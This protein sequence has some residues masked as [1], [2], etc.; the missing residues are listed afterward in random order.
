MEEMQAEHQVPWPLPGSLFSHPQLAAEPRGWGS[1]PSL[2]DGFTD[3]PPTP[4]N[5]VKSLSEAQGQG[6]SWL[7]PAEEASGGGVSGWGSL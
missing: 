5:V 7:P 6:T 2:V 1:S 3:L 4:T